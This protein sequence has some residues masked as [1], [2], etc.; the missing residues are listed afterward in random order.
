MSLFITSIWFDFTNSQ[1]DCKTLF[2]MLTGCFCFSL[3]FLTCSGF[4]FS[5]H[6][7]LTR[8]RGKNLEVH[9][10]HTQSFHISLG[11]LAIV[12]ATAVLVPVERIKIWKP[13]LSLICI[14]PGSVTV[15]MTTV[16]HQQGSQA[17][18][19][20]VFCSEFS[21]LALGHWAPGFCFFCST[22]ESSRRVLEAK[23]PCNF[24]CERAVQDLLGRSAWVCLN[25]AFVWV[26]SE[27][28]S[29]SQ[30]QQFVFHSHGAPLF[31]PFW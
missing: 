7:C 1:F 4:G 23:L 31:A 8:R 16:L 3:M 2:I 24:F 6:P 17:E 12:L 25:S 10:F 28:L 11:G 19:V 29:I 30:R 20:I 22:W 9:C 27:I 18:H 5:N 21:E 14:N 13:I 26:L 15:H